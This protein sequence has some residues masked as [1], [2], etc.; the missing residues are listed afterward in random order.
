MTHYGT[1][2]SQYFSNEVDDIR[3]TAVYGSEGEKLGQLDDVIFDHSTMEIQYIVVDSGGWLE[4][5]KFLLPADQITGDSEHPGEF[6]AN[7]NK[8]DIEQLLRY[9][10]RL[11]NSQD[12]WKKYEEEYKK[13]WHAA[14]VQ[15]RLG[16]DRNITPEEEPGDEQ[17]SEQ[18]ST[19]SEASASELFPE[20]LASV[21]S[22][23]TP[24]GSKIAMRPGGT[25]ARA[26]EAASG[27]TLLK[28]RW[29]S[30]VEHLRRLRQPIVARCSHCEAETQKRRN[31]T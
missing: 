27:T 10:A 12:A 18:A 9:D 8:Q 14:P 17:S 3:G 24:R 4:G 7:V 25:V 21:F 30:F 26:E 28:P 2:G 19:A 31:V 5:A 6:A 1:L 13:A 23:P 15:H 16:S 29:D 20:R 11:L 22:D